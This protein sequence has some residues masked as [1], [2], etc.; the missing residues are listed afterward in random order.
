MG[1][2]DGI[3]G[4]QYHPEVRVFDEYRV[5]TPAGPDDEQPGRERPPKSWLRKS[6]LLPAGVALAIVLACLAVIRS[7]DRPPTLTPEQ[8]SST[9]T[10]EVA[11]GVDA[12]LNVPPAGQTVF[13]VI[14]PS[15]VFISSTPNGSSPDETASGAGVIVDAS[16]QI[17]T[18]RHVVADSTSIEVTFADGTESPA[19]IVSEEA[20]NDI[21]V[22]QP[23]ELPS[24]VV[25]A[26]LGGGIQIGDDVY[27]T[28]HPFGF[29]DSLTAGV[30][31]GLDRTV[32]I[33]VGQTLDGL[34]QFDAAVNPGNSGGP[35]LN[36]AGQVVGIV[37]ALANPAQE[38]FFVGL[39]FAVPIATAGGAAG[40]PQQ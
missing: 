26:V 7:N 18:A 29:A 33:A 37:T 19:T 23:A 14:Q 8:I 40:A 39:G 17:L 1:R 27:A 5:E 32:P 4:P 3:E 21:A 10:S 22:L 38:K 25:P 15:V 6:W 28:G 12:A 36:S 2:G 16:G 20:D 24:V 13:R 35:L 30:V 31:S 11:K 34:I 9:I